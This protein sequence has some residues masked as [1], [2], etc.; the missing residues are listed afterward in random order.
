[1][2]GWIQIQEG[3]KN[4]KKLNKVEKFY[5]LKCWIF[6]IEGWRLLLKLGYTLLRPRDKN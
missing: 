6:S 1:L 5:V 2:V 3:K 4:E